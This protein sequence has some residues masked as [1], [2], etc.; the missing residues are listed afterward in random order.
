MK[1][2]FFI[3][4]LLAALLSISTFAAEDVVYLKNGGNGNGSSPE[5]AL[6]DMA[7]AFIALPY[8]GTIVVCGDYTLAKSVNYDASLPGF[9]SPAAD[10]TVTV[11]SSY[12]GTDYGARLICADGSR[13]VCSANTTFD[14]ITI[15]IN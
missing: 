7:D 13:Y 14:N 12:G 3:V 9:T 5:N 8:G 11:T 1:K 2:I 6:G 4:F 10:G 15:F